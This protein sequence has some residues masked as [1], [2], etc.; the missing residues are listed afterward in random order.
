MAL[1]VGVPSDALSRLKHAPL[2]T[3]RCFDL[4]LYSHNQVTGRF[5]GNRTQNR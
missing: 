4:T 2:E 1:R 3:D 5:C